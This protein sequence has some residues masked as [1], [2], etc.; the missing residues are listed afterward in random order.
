MFYLSRNTYYGSKH[1]IAGLRASGVAP[2]EAGHSYGHSDS[3]GAIYPRSAPT[4]KG[5][6]HPRE[7]RRLSC[8][9]SPGQ[10]LW[11]RTHVLARECTD[12]ALTVCG[13]PVRYRIRRQITLE[14]EG[15]AT[16]PAATK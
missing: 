10:R 5:E 7:S 11:K 9:R 8:L 4:G 3:P 16:L 12:A 6:T 1:R 13:V 15:Q 14:A 2:A